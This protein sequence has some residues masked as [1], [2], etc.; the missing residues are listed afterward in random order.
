MRSSFVRSRNLRQQQQQRRQ[1]QRRGKHHRLSGCQR[2]AAAAAAA[3]HSHYTEQCRPPSL[4]LSL[5]LSQCAEEA[6]FRGEPNG[7]AIAIGAVSLRKPARCHFG[8]P[9]KQQGRG[10]KKSLQKLT[11]QS[12]EEPKGRISE[13]LCRGATASAY[14]FSS[15]SWPS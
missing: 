13:K 10:V 12:S 14:M 5:L 7:A 9:F 2:F 15:P 1:Q 11:L 6:S 8:G 4:S 3:A